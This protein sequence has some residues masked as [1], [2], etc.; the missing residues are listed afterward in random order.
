MALASLIPASQVAASETEKQEAR[1]ASRALSRLGHDRVRVEAVA[2]NAP[3]QTFVLPAAAVRMLTDILAHLAEG[4]LV[5]VIPSEAEL[6]TQQAADMLNVS[7]PYLVKLLEH[8]L[9]PYHHVGTHRR[10]LC[11]DLLAYRARLAQT[12]RNALAELVAEGQ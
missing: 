1:T 7:R 5:T 2:D 8:D 4:K 3:P 6:T 12:R 11:S 9:I 10:V